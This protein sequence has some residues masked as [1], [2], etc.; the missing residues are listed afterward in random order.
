MASVLAEPGQHALQHVLV[1]R[2]GAVGALAR[3]DRVLVQALEHELH[4]RGRVLGVRG[5]E[6]LVRQ[7]AE[8][9]H[10]ASRVVNSA[11]GIR[12][13]PR[14]ACPTRTTR[15]SAGTRDGRVLASAAEASRR[16]AA[17]VL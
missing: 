17:R 1:G 6:V 7:R 9:L 2:A 12:P 3:Q 5:L 16:A 13:R 11:Y 10:G 15:R 8:S 14:R 4:A